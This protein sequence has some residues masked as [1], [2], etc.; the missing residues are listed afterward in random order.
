MFIHF[1][2]TGFYMIDGW[3]NFQWNTVCLWEMFTKMDD[4][5]EGTN[6]PIKVHLVYKTGSGLQLCRKLFDMQSQSSSAY[7]QFT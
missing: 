7:C 3:S 1:L 4:P 6:L 2:I 5:Q